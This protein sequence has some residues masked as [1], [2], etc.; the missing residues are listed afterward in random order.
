MIIAFQDSLMYLCPAQLRDKTVMPQGCTEMDDSQ[1]D[2][3]LDRLIAQQSDVW[4]WTQSNPRRWID[5][6]HHRFCFVKA[7]G[8]LVHSPDGQCLMIY[9]E[10]HWDLPKGM[11][12]RG[13]TL[14]MAALREV[15]EETGI[16]ALPHPALIAKTYHIYDKYGGWHLKQTSWFAM[17][18]PLAQPRPQTEESITQALWVTHDECINRLSTSFASLRILAHTIN[19]PNNSAH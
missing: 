8:G 19:Q 3:C 7:A 15:M 6:L 11:V 18:A 17:Q 1:P 5:F 2:C 14:R 12:E 9:R 16:E 10:G 4:V 13:E